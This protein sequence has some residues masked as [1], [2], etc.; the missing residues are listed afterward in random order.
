MLGG[1]PGESIGGIPIEGQQTVIAC[2]LACRNAGA[3]VSNRL[4]R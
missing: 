1:G 3:Y 4:Q 2:Q